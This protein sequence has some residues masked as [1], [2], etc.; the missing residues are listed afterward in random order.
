M[1]AVVPPAGVPM[2]IGMQFS[3]LAGLNTKAGG[4]GNEFWLH[5][6]SKSMRSSTSFYPPLQMNVNNPAIQAPPNDVEIVWPSVRTVGNAHLGYAIG[7]AI[8]LYCDV[9][10]NQ[11]GGYKPSFQACARKWE[12]APGGHKALNAP[13]IK[14]FYRYFMTKDGRPELMWLYLGSHNLSKAAWGELEKNGQQLYIKSYELGVLFIPAKM[15]K[16]ERTFSLTPSNERLGMRLPPKFASAAAATANAPST[17]PLHFIASFEPT[18]RDRTVV[19]FP[20]PH[21]IPAQPYIWG[22]GLENKPWAWDMVITEP[23]SLGK[24]KLIAKYDY[25]Y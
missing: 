14:T 16:T 15:R 17:E 9:V 18:P 20:I 21:R 7:G 4:K 3:S 23:D 25:P 6:L 2:T 8:P 11:N 22:N 24:L 10:R 5:E 1:S 19:H 13:H 12:G